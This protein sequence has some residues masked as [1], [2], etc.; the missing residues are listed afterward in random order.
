ML[1]T[2][3]QAIF[4]TL[5][6]TFSLFFS[7]GLAGPLTS[8]IT[9]RNDETLF[10][11]FAFI[12]IGTFDEVDREKMP[13]LKEFVWRRLNKTLKPEYIQQIRKLCRRLQKDR[14]FKYKATMLALNSSPPPRIRFL[15]EELLTYLKKNKRDI[16]RAMET[17]RGLEELPAW[18]TEF[19]QKAH[20]RELYKDCRPWYDEAISKYRQKV[21][22]LLNKALTYLKMREEEISLSFNQVV[23]IPNLIGPR[24]TAMGPI[25]K[26]VKY[27]IYTPWDNVSWSPHE[28]I[29]EMVSPLTYS[30]SYKEAIN[31]IVG[32]VW[33]DV[34]KTSAGRYYPDPLS[35][36]DECL[37]RTL[38]HV[39]KREWQKPWGKEEIRALL[40]R[41][42]ERGFVL[43][44]Q[45]Y[46]A[47]QDYE[48]SGLTFKDYFPQFLS[49]LKA[50]NELPNPVN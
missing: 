6:T 33:D 37:V 4:L 44:P 23:I 40:Q 45:M 38:D 26:G 18:L 41:Q 5:L 31:E 39:V 11:T 12:T 2:N 29:H 34:K 47:L 17:F 14:L 36:F 49:S 30:P 9:I 43:C 27:D 32:P 48:T 50:K 19:Y 28:F 24:G 20:I 13:P 46:Q 10:T 8:K 35:F 16:E 3:K 15:K 42:A 22:S 1:K 7:V 21:T 25:W